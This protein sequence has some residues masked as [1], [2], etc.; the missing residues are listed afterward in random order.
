MNANTAITGF[1]LLKQYSILLPLQICLAHRHTAF[2]D[3]CQVE[4]TI[5]RETWTWSCCQSPWFCSFPHLTSPNG[6]KS[7]LCWNDWEMTLESS[8]STVLEKCCPK[9]KS[10]QDDLKNA[11]RIS[12]KTSFIKNLFQ[13]FRLQEEIVLGLV[14]M[15]ILLLIRSRTGHSLDS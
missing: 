15:L 13:S 5:M 9:W 8:A 14:L 1:S 6:F 11:Q 2:L 3:K 4:N 10:K 12:D 7:P